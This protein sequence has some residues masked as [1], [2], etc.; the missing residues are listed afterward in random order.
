M[1]EN[2]TP[3]SFASA[4]RRLVRPVPERPERSHKADVLDRKLAELVR[5]IDNR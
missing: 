5:R 4:E 1:D 3:V 2:E